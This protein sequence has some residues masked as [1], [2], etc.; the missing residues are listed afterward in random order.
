MGQKTLKVPQ[1]C[2]LPESVDLFI[3]H[4][5]SSGQ[6]NATAFVLKNTMRSLSFAVVTSAD[7]SDQKLPISQLGR[8][9]HAVVLLSNRWLTNSRFVASLSAL[10]GM[11]KK[12]T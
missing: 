11:C 8:C 5:T 4:D 12:T 3:I 2:S 9:Q 6:A 1:L 7:Y 10:D